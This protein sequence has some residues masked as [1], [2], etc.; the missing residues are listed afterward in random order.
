M[1][2][3]KFKIISPTIALFEQNGRQ[4]ARHVP[5]GTIIEID[6][7]TLNHKTLIPVVLNGQPVMMFPQ[8]VRSRGE[9]IDHHSA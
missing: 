3:I 7:E 9:R 6:A 5:S 2:T 4:V 8:D 1:P